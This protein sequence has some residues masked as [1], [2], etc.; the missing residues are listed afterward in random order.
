MA[1][2]TRA[3]AEAMV[4]DAGDAERGDGGASA[5]AAAAPPPP[6]IPLRRAGLARAA[7]MCMPAA[8]RPECFAGTGERH[9]LEDSANASAGALL[10]KLASTGPRADDTKPCRVLDGLFVGSGRSAWNLQRLLGLGVTHV[11]NAAPQTES[12]FHKELTYLT[13]DVLDSPEAPIGEHFAR[14][15]RFIEEARRG[16]GA[17]LVHCHGGV[18]RAAAIVLA[19]LLGCE[20]RRFCDAW[21]LL[22]A[23]RPQVAPNPG[24]IMQ[25]KRFEQEVGGGAALMAVG[26]GSG[27]RGA[28]PRSG[29]DEALVHALHRMAPRERAR[30]ATLSRYFRDLCHSPQAWSH[31]VLDCPAMLTLK[32]WSALPYGN[33]PALLLR[34]LVGRSCNAGLARWDTSCLRSLRVATC[35]CAAGCGL[36]DRE[37]AQ[38]QGAIVDAV[39]LC[40]GFRTLE[41]GRCVALPSLLAALAEHAGRG[42]AARVTV[43]FEHTAASQ[44]DADE[45]TGA[46]LAALACAE[47]AAQEGPEA[48]GLVFG[49]LALRGFG[50]G[51][52]VQLLRAL[53]SALRTARVAALALEGCAVS[54]EGAL[55]LVTAFSAAPLGTK[56]ALVR[57]GVAPDVAASLRELVPAG[58]AAGLVIEPS[59]AA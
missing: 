19:Y 55:Q 51:A 5:S 49:S 17:V 27:D 41:V 23:T 1:V 6:T 50:P 28:R 25:L 8:L 20:G 4:L 48:G 10:G 42:C 47:E 53:S 11:V 32:P 43:S 46:L 13:V 3:A 52:N 35:E 21:D 54:E 38:L 59:T 57:C 36:P 9:E 37:A 2:A 34:Q 18:S 56:L 31:L 22:K 58:R 39:R 7:P 33:G 40:P 29:P 26:D 44:V 45:V 14:A 12:C 24:F 30:C 16:G 15:N